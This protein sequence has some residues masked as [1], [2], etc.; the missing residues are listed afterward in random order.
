MFSE[1]TSFK[2][3]VSYIRRRLDR[4]RLVAGTPASL[5]RGALRGSK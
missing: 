3:R 2:V 1:T 4:L 5:Q